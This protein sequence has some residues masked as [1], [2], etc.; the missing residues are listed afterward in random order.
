MNLFP[1]LISW[2]LTFGYVPQMCDS[3]NQEYV[4]IYKN[5]IATVAQIGLSAETN[6][7]YFEVYTDI[8]N[9]QYSNIKRNSVSFAP[10]R[11]NYSIGFNFKPSENMMFSIDH[12]CDHPVTFYTSGYLEYPYDAAITKMTVTLHGVTEIF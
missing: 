12:Q 10:F 4:S 8:E 5:E 6:N 11:V 7:K 3:V 1:L 2:F 9:Y